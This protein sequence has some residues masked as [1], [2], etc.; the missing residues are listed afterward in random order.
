MKT[1]RFS[2]VHQ[3]LTSAL[4]ELLPT[5]FL[6]RTSDL[7]GYMYSIQYN[8]EIIAVGQGDGWRNYTLTGEN[9]DTLKSL[10]FIIGG[11]PTH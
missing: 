5:M 3:T 8:K 7:S 6:H 1:I 2:L 11:Q 9:E 10:I 4:T